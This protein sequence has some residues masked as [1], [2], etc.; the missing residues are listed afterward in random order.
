MKKTLLT[1]L[2]FTFCLTNY[3]QETNTETVTT[4]YLVRHAEKDISDKTNR[5]PR[6]TEKGKIRANNLVAVF[7]NVKFDAVYSTNYF[8]TLN[9]AKPTA[10][11]QKLETIIYNVKGFNFDKFK[12]ETKGKNILIV[13]HS[14]T[15]P[16]FS[17]KLLG[18]EKYE[19]LDESIYSNLYIITLTGDSANSILLKID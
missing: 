13:G 12:A 14:N 11:N 5:N 3:A 8:R 6:L 9:T 4:Y 19:N 16:H 7:E 1:I 10:L 17:N 18:K 15:T 2:I